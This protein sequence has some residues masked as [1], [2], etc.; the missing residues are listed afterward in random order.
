MDLN[1]SVSGIIQ[2]ETWQGR[3]VYSQSQKDI[4]QKLFQHSPYPDKATREKL[5]KEIGIAESKIQIW[6][7][8]HRAK[9][10]QLGSGCSLGEDQTQGQDQTQPRIQ[11]YLPKE[12]RRDQTSLT[13]SQ[14]DILVG[15]FERKRFPDIVARKK[16]AKQTGIRESRIKMWYQNRRS[17]YPGQSRSEPMNPLADGPNERPDLTVQQHQIDL[18]TLPSR[19]YHFPSS[20]SFS[21]NKTFLLALLPSHVSFPV[22]QGQNIMRTQPTQAVQGGEN[23]SSTLTLTN[24]VP[25]PLT[26]G[27]DLLDTQNPFWPQYQEKCQDHKEQTDTG[28]LQLKDNS[29]PHSE[30]KK[31]PPQDLGQVDISYIMQWWDEGY[32]ALLAEWDPQKGTD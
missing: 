13:R 17:L 6:F 9:Q 5:A 11:D 12:A 24:Y 21:G 27:G 20:N 14:S 32:Q 4:L 28:V 29:Q 22:I 25:I 7:K 18:S 30:H 1:N 15:A 8:N 23:A 10:R 31:Q 3:V 2:K 19:S 26:L 16:L